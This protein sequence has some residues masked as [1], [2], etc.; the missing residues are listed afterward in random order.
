MDSDC[1]LDPFD[2]NKI[3]TPFRVIIIGPS[4]CG[5]TTCNLDLL[6]RHT[7]IP[8]GLIMA[9]SDEATP[10]YE[11]IAPKLLIH[12][13]Y[14][15]QELQSFLLAQEEKCFARNHGVEDVNGG[16]PDTRG[17]VIL[18]DLQ[19][20]AGDWKRNQTILRLLTSGRNF[21]ASVI[22][23]MQ[24]PKALGPDLR[25]N[26]KY[27]FLYKPN[28]IGDV[29]KYQE[30]FCSQ[31][32]V[33]EL[34]DVYKR[35]NPYECVVV[36]TT[37]SSLDVRKTCFWFKARDKVKIPSFRLFSPEIR[38]FCDSAFDPNY[39]FREMQKK[40]ESIG[41]KKHHQRIV[42]NKSYQ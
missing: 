30:N 40:K 9:G 21:D 26:F 29:K 28:N 5:K 4:E 41:D 27:V 7:S 38:N 17:L 23:I 11:K 20:S 1:P 24:T 10:V 8:T 16:T 2:L 3:K 14:K 39:K 33:K 42:F 13:S 37:E 34:E 12:N 18:D 19:H 35:S 32:S 22:C 36:D 6:S 25:A 31:M 15:D